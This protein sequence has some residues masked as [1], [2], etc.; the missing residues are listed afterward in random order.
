MGLIDL[1]SIIVA[2]IGA[3]AA[4]LAQRAASKAGEANTKVSGRL[5]AERNAYERARVFDTETIDRQNEELKKLREEN[6]RLQKE[7]AAVKTRL[8]RVE[9]MIPEWERLLNERA[10]EGNDY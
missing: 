4:I 1:G 6:E 5:E 2:M 10:H 7:L 9:G 8:R 3:I